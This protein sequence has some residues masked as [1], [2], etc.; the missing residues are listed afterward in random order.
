[1]RPR[2]SVA[3]SPR[4]RAPPPG[5]RSPPAPRRAQEPHSVRHGREKF[6]RALRGGPPRTRGARR[7]RRFVQPRGSARRVRH[8]D[9]GGAE[10]RAGGCGVPSGLPSAS[11][12]APGSGSRRGVSSEHGPPRRR[13]ASAPRRGGGRGRGG[14]RTGGDGDD[15]LLA[16]A[17][18]A[19]HPRHAALLRQGVDLVMARPRPRGGGPREREALGIRGGLDR[20]HLR[21]RGLEV[22][23]VRVRRESARR[24]A[25]SFTRRR[26]WLSPRRVYCEGG[27]PRV[28]AGSEEREGEGRIVG[29]AERGQTAHP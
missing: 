24:S 28:G 19:G 12:A 2:V 17:R 15:R 22:A 8:R 26:G 5:A 13:S 25:G 7:R 18:G 1:M 29:T 21:E 6:V 4:Q 14:R 20:C 9:R 16:L 27:R 10:D 11:R 23:D 3:A